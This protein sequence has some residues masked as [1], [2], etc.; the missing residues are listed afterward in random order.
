[1]AVVFDLDGTLFDH[2]GAAAAG[3][4]GWLA[5]MGVEASEELMRSWLEAEER[6]VS[7]WQRS[8]AT[9]RHGGALMTSRTR[10]GWLPRPACG[11]P[12]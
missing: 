3:V 2:R 5:G 9:K 8:R 11:S 7:G 10:W 1:M 12:C 4:R 6:H